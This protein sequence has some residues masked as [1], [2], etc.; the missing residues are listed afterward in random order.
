MLLLSDVL[1]NDC[2]APEE[3]CG[4]A[5]KAAAQG[6]ET[7]SAKRLQ[8]SFILTDNVVLKSMQQWQVSCCGMMMC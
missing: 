6:I 4:A 8:E 3:L 7:Q 2:A 5:V 1:D